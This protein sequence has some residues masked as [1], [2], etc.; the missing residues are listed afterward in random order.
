[1]YLIL[2]SAVVLKPWLIELQG[3]CKVH[4]QQELVMQ[5]AENPNRRW[6]PSMQ[7]PTLACTHSYLVKT[8]FSLCVIN[9]RI[10]S[11]KIWFFIFFLIT[12]L[13]MFIVIFQAI[14]KYLKKNSG[15]FLNKF[16]PEETSVNSLGCVHLYK[17]VRIQLSVFCLFLYIRNCISLFVLLCKLLLLFINVSQIFSRCIEMYFNCSFLL[18]Q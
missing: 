8:W 17:H 4:Q 10:F 15:P 13:W 3:L 14:Q 16:I 12:K 7:A 11:P 5:E 9:S 6:P 18:L 2:C 1:M